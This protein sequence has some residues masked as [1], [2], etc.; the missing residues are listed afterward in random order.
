[1]TT[2]PLKSNV[3]DKGQYFS[4]VNAVSTHISDILSRHCGPLARYAALPRTLS[5]GSSSHEFTKDGISIVEN[6]SYEDDIIAE[7]L[8]E[9]IAYMGRRVDS[10][11][12]DGTTTAMLILSDVLKQISDTIASS[13]GENISK[14]DVMDAIND[15]RSAIGANTLT[16][17]SFAKHLKI[18]HKKARYL[19]AYNQAMISSKG[20]VEVAKCLGRIAQSIPIESLYGQYYLDTDPYEN[21]D[22]IIYTEHDHDIEV[23]VLANHTIY[24]HEMMTQYKCDD[25]QVFS[26]ASD[27]VEPNPRF[28]E[29]QAHLQAIMD[30]L[31][32]EGAPELP[33]DHVSVATMLPK[34]LVII[35]P[36]IHASLEKLAAWINMTLPVSK[37]KTIQDRRIVI[38]KLNHGHLRSTRYY[39]TAIHLL[40]NKKSSD[41]YTNFKDAIIDNV[42]VNIRNHVCYL[43]N[44][45]TKTNDIY[46]PYLKHPSKYPDYMQFYNELKKHIDDIYTRHIKVG[47]TEQD[48][49]TYVTLWRFLHTQRSATAKVR[50][51]THS[52]IAMKT[53]MEDAYGAVVSALEFGFI[54]N[55]VRRMADALEENDTSASTAIKNALYRVLR[56]TSHVLTTPD[57]A[58]K[59]DDPIHHFVYNPATDALLE[60]SKDTITTTPIALVQPVKGYYEILKRLEELLP[61]LVATETYITKA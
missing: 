49:Y 42:R 4:K 36:T 50:G 33:A 43:W 34:D 61:Q 23:G 39:A 24:N 40:A 38:L 31:K 48:E 41:Y 37:D 45:Y 44:L 13:H 59:A 17:K 57:Y 58:S 25:A 11:C 51:S 56:C 46:H 19:I 28:F 6:I 15:I 22:A 53:V 27:L 18:S 29:I 54:F 20:N 10:A 26:T 55:G 1:M 7:N 8:R 2:A 21:D 5:D 3:L 47:I 30:A 14:A 35:A 52:V 16:A 9:A 12:H 32:A 60:V